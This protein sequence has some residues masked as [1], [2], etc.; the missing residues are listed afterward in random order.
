MGTS[1]A[2]QLQKLA[3]PQTG[4]LE[5][6]KKRPSLLFDPKEAANLRGETF[7]QIGLDGFE[8][9]KSRNPAFEQFENTLFHPTSKDFERSV[10]D[11]NA[12]KKL[13]RNIRRFCL[14]LSPYFMLNCSYKALEW[15]VY[16][17]SIHEFNREELLML[18]LPYYETNIFVRAIQLL[19]LKDPKDRWHWL[20]PLQ[21]P[22]VHLAKNTLFGH[23]ASS[24]Q[25]LQFVS[26]FVLEVVREHK[27]T[28]NLGMV[29]N[30][31]STT[32]AGALH[33]SKE[34]GEPQVVQMLPVLLEGTF[35]L[36]NLLRNV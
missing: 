24:P 31:Y 18:I 32:F 9:L 12:N 29:F 1:L 28:A 20:R 13:N 25:F 5:R 34:V 22:G 17:Y 27:R 15:L 19:K 8:E 30:F 21:K 36:T 23:A 33:F 3:V 7:F 35:I 2:E 11:S 4:L 10:H 26:K 6:D 14:L 16:R